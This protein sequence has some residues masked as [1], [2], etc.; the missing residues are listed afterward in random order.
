MDGVFK[1]CMVKCQGYEKFGLSGYYAQV[2]DNGQVKWQPL[3][4]NYR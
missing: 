4:E 2:M 1:E 3:Q